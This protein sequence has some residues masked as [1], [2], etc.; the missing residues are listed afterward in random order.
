MTS[1]RRT[2]YPRLKAHR[3]NQELEAIYQPTED[4]LHFVRANAK[5]DAQRLT[6]LLLL[7][8][9]Q[10]LGY[11]PALELVSDNLRYYLCSQLQVSTETSLTVDAKKTR[12]RYR[13]LI[14]TY[15]NVR[16]YS[17]GGPAIV[18]SATRK[19]AY[20]M[21]D[22]ADLINV[23]IEQ[24]IHHRY[25][26]P[27]FSTLDRRVNHIRHQ[28]HQALYTQVAAQLND[29]QRQV[30]D[31]LL[32]VQ[33]GHRT[34]RFTRLK[35]APGPATLKHLR[36]WEERL[37]WLDTLPDARFLLQEVA[38]TKIKEFATQA[39]AL[40]VGDMRDV[41]DAPRRYTLL[42]CLLYQ[43]Q[44]YT[45]DQLVT[46]LLKRMRLIHHRAKERLRDL[47]DQHREMTEQMVSA[48]AEIAHHATETEADAA[49][50]QQVRQ[51]LA[52][53]GGP[54]SLA[55]QYR[56]VS[57]YHNDNH[58]PL[59]WNYYRSHRTVLFRLMTQLDIRSATQDQTLLRALHF[60]HHYQT[61]RRDY[62]P[63]EIALDFAGQRW[64]TLIRTRAE[65]EVVLRRRELETCV[66]SY[67]AEGLRSGDLF[68]L[69]SEDYADY[70]TQ[71]LS[72]EVCRPRVDAYCE[73]LAI[74]ST[75]KGLVQHLRDRLA[76]A[77]QKL[78]ESMPESAELSF[79]A[80]GKPYL[81][82]TDAQPIP[83]GTEALEAAIQERMPE[84]GLLDILKRV[85]YW[86][87]FTR[88][89]RPLSGSDPKLTEPIARYIVTVFGYGTNLGPA[90]T[91][92][93][94]QGLVTLR[95]LQRIND[96]H[97]STAS[98]EAALR[99]VIHDYTRFQLP[100]LWGTGRAAV[101]DGTQIELRENNLLGERHVRYG[102]YGG[103]AYHH[104]SDTYIA[105][106]S[107]FI[108]C[109][110]W[111]AVYILDGLL[112]NES[113]LQPDT[114]HADTQGQS[115]PVF[116]LAYLLGIKLM[117]R[118]RN[119]RALT[120]YRPDKETRYRH[121]DSL[122]TQTIDWDLIETH[123]QDLLQVVLSIQAGTVLPSMLLQKLGSYARR[124]RLYRAFR[125]LGC[126]ARTLFL[127]EYI[128]DP[129]LR[130]YIHAATTKIESYNS[131][132]DWIAFGGHGILTPRDPVEQEKRIKYMDLVA[133]AVMLHNVADMT[134]VLHQLGQEGYTI[135]L[136]M[137]ARLS[138]YL[139]QH[140][141]RFGD[142]VLDMD[143]RPEPLQPGKTFLTV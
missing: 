88:H 138:P 22:P 120:F 33:P 77:A 94:T 44:V 51:V 132:L 57:A 54:E 23:A 60:I 83:P 2:A 74:P 9:H 141:K 92:R 71:L 48:L 5:G 68:V 24:L 114:L 85:Q 107:H 20:T 82:R 109:G 113:D 18:E 10:L 40:E 65:G 8:C 73:A 4:E 55:D 52:A 87:D 72:W 80:D 11:I 53:Y 98:L 106:F 86:V 95:S 50:G 46:M 121:I 76:R 140:I 116:G 143:A 134:D 81:R 136:Q 70:R 15:L 47:Q 14:R 62:L 63:D 39:H 78:D 130:R 56:L 64:Q 43:A 19:S 30:L 104:I 89:F 93:H 25:E 102:G 41:Y 59:V 118:I 84:Y 31:D 137:V 69:G 126:A 128:S 67:L 66:F 7:K 99:D 29:E 17:Q 112:K 13:Q 90:Q 108:A 21:S 119:W 79:D 37:A 105:L 38:N 142:Y 3:T 117:P 127:L 115:E 61:A 122:F 16:S 96:Q 125:E 6:L 131:F 32:E 129:P 97:I 123:W 12:Y 1:I 101:A 36:H 100:F 49:F 111:E 58:L 28:V 110:V 139:T 91:A 135:T 124:N 27:A 42:L 26:L 103:I 75:P 35:E 45:R 133:N 34:T